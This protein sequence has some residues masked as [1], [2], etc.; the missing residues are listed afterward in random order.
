MKFYKLKSFDEKGLLYILDMIIFHRIHLSTQDKMNDIEEGWWEY[1][2][3]KDDEYI[4]KA[5]ELR[6]I[7]DS[8]SVV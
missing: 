2:G 1:E 7:V 6:K 5:G 4:K 8:T 3:I